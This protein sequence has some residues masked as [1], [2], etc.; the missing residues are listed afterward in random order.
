MS[1]LETMHP[2]RETRK[3]RDLVVL[4]VKVENLMCIWNKGLPQPCES[5]LSL[6]G[7]GHTM[8][9]LCLTVPRDQVV[10]SE[11]TRGIII[12]VN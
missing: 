7:K 3:P 6:K 11:I 8:L 4:G 5:Q 9:T 2:H 10:R 12:H 1:I